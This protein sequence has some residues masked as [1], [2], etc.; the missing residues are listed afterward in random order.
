MTFTKKTRFQNHY[1]FFFK[2]NICC[3]SARPPASQST[4]PHFPSSFD[5][6]RNQKARTGLVH[7]SLVIEL[8]PLNRTWPHFGTKS[9]SQSEAFLP[10]SLRC[11]DVDNECD[12]TLHIK[13]SASIRSWHFVLGLGSERLLGS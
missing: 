2:Q 3:A 9:L 7:R 6:M 12:I 8:H 5:R 1:A 13:V 10:L 11:S 4:V